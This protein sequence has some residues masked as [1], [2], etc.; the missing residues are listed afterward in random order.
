MLA[1]LPAPERSLPYAS[2]TEVDI[3]VFRESAMRRFVDAGAFVFEAWNLFELQLFHRQCK[4][5]T[6]KI[7]GR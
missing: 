4:S 1:P 2:Q 6:T 3:V 5:Q 7:I